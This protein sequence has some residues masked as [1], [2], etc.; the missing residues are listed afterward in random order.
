MEQL[1]KDFM[2]AARTLRKQ[3]TFTATAIAT[4]A[5]AI[6]ASTAMFSV[7]EATLLRPL[8]FRTP[9]RL[10]YLW[11]VA[12]PQRAIR[13]GSIIEVQDWNRMNRTFENIA[14]Y[15]ST[16]LNIASEQ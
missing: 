13:G 11:G 2:F 3:P 4:L 14:I 8:P 6:G 15:N 5:L 12:G 10:T 7:V 16:S 9:E 1:G